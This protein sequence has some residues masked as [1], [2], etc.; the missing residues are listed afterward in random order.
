MTW[1]GLTDGGRVPEVLLFPLLVVVAVPPGPPGPPLTVAL[2]SAT[3]VDKPLSPVAS[4]VPVVATEPD[5]SSP[6]ATE[7]VPETGFSLPPHPASTARDNMTAR[8]PAI[9]F[10]LIM[11]LLTLSFITV[12]FKGNHADICRFAV[13]LPPLPHPLDTA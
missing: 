11:Q 1:P 5:T 6:L 13:L 7:A 10:L 9:I 8:R 12:F 2:L 4:S 3:V